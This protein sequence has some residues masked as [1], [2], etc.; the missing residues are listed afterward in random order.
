M[1]ALTSFPNGASSFGIPMLGA[2]L[3]IPNP[4]TSCRPIFVDGTY[5]ADGNDGSSPSQPVATISRALAIAKAGATIFVAFGTYDENLVV[6]T[7]YITIVGSTYA[8]YG[9]PDVAP[10]SGVALTVNAQGFRT[11]HCRYVAASDVVKQRG[12]GFH[13]EGCVF[14]GDGNGAGTALMW[15]IPS[16]TDDSYTASEGTVKGNLFR[17]SGGTALKFDTGAAPAVGVGSTD[18]VIVGN[19]FRDNTGVDIVTADAGTG[20]YS[21][22][23]VLIATNHF[24][25]KN[26]ATYIDLTTTNG[27]AAGDQSGAVND[28]FFA[29][30][31]MTTTKIKAVGTA[32]TFT[33]NAITTGIFDGSG[34]D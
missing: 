15:L 8:G 31:T 33:R 21:V 10:S 27:G 28:N 5:G 2:G 12:N 34:L 11:F 9:R 24:M 7:D 18:N 6:N 23:K 3:T 1:P 19:V 29:S 20:T 13:Y 32:F 30:D 14:D 4:K 25:D 17:G 22:Q 26:K 16:D